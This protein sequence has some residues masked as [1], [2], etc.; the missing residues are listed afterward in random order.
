MYHLDWYEECKY[1]G[2][3]LSTIAASYILNEGIT[4][5]PEER[6]LLLEKHKIAAIDR[7]VIGSS[8]KKAADASNITRDIGLALPLLLL[9]PEKSRA[10]YGKILVMTGEVYLITSGLTLLTKNLALRSRPFVF[11]ESVDYS[12]KVHSG[13]QHSFFSGHTSLT[14]AISF[15][16]ARVFSDLYPD[17][18]LKPFV[19]GT[20]AVL[21]ALTG[22]LRVK[23]GK[24]FPTDVVTGY[25]VG[26][27]I[28]YFIPQLHKQK[29]RKTKKKL[30]ITPSSQGVSLVLD[31]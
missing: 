22:Y 7:W 28:G 24:H 31:L 19:W 12:H 4:P 25:A 27:L 16:S 9:I 26:A 8:S 30:K 6:V 20:A 3:G 5:Y 13:A 21:P 23:S 11:D 10:E 29:I 14:S 2:T 17:S 18:K 15:F 1:V